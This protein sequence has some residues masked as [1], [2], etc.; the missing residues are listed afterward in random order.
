MCRPKNSLHQML[1]M[2]S[3]KGFKDIFLHWRLCETNLIN[4]NRLYYCMQQQGGGQ[5][6]SQ[7]HIWVLQLTFTTTY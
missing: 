7:Q 6:G 2:V 3:T 4:K 1:D 5:G